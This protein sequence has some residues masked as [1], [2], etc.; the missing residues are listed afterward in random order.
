MDSKIEASGLNGRKR[1]SAHWNFPA[2]GVGHGPG[3]LAGSFFFNAIVR[4]KARRR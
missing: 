1:L 4:P 3:D 2:H